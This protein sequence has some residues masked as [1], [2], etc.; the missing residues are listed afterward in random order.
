VTADG[1]PARER[2]LAVAVIAVG[3]TMA[4]LDSS[5]ANVALPTLSREL[6]ASPA[7]TVWVVNGFQIAVATTLLTF[8]ALGDALGY[9][10]VYTAG[11]VVF[12]IG[13]L[14]CAVSHSLPALVASRVLQ[15]F[16]ASAIMSV[17]PALYRTIFPTS[18]LGR[19]LGISALVVASSAS[20]GPTIGGAILAVLPWPWL[21][22][23]N[24][25]LGAIDMLL[26]PRVLPKAEHAHGRLDALSAVL[27]ALALGLFVIALDGFAHRASPFVIAATFIA[28][29]SFGV[30]F[31]AR[32][33]KAR[34]P[35]LP[36]DMFAIPRF[37][38][39]AA[40]S[41]C[42]FVAQGLAFV[43]LPFLF[44]GPL[45]YSPVASGL[46]IT[47]WP[48]CIAVLAPI[49]GRLAD[50]YAPPLLCTIGLAVLCVGLALLAAL[51]PH[52]GPFDIVWRGMICGI[53]FGLFQSPNNRE[54]LGSVPRRQ[55]GSASGVLA[56]VR[57]SGQAIG[58]AFVAIALGT[59]AAALA[60]GGLHHAAIES[61]AQRTL[62]A[63]SASALVAAAVSGLRLAMRTSRES[64]SP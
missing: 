61:A 18:Q 8:A 13:S 1:L 9:R 44:Q 20:A 51:P 33:R 26:A 22:A 58:A 53:G 54:I 7:V 57:V 49:A 14:L 15:G 21:F 3:T 52:A 2:R 42:S 28:S 43:A 36:L 34:F 5:I 64:S 6:H 12:T 39:A 16:G 56:T 25:P 17:G 32:Q 35:V 10:V 60:G 11:I 24:V 30:A 63:A 38:L 27:S 19:G 23:L 31:L 41:F 47:P 48:L 62:T 37:S 46:L 29:V 4:V 45:G 50:R 59:A 55:S 40:T